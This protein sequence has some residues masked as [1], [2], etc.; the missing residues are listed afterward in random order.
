MKKPK[1][2]LPPLKIGNE[3]QLSALFLSKIYVGDNSSSTSQQNSNAL[4]YSIAV[5]TSVETETKNEVGQW[6]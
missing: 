4:E 3:K 2:K 5:T 6:F 1:L